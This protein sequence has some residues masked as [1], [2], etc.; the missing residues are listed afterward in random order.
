MQKVPKQ[1]YGKIKLS[2]PEFS[3]ISQ[4]RDT[5]IFAEREVSHMYLVIYSGK[6]E[7]NGGKVGEE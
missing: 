4:A 5:L 2:V 6:I 1:F 7:I 3:R